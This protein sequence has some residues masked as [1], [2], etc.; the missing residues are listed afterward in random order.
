MTREE[1]LRAK[2]SSVCVGDDLGG[3]RSLYIEAWE[4]DFEVRPKNIGGFRSG[5]RGLGR[6]DHV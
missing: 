2:F 1:E 3:E 6:S 5:A 4:Y